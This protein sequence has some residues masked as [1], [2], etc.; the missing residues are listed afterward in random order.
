MAEVVHIQRKPND[1]KKD[2]DIK[3]RQLRQSSDGRDYCEE[4]Y[5]W[6][7]TNERQVIKSAKL[8]YNL[9]DDVSITKD[10]P[11]S[12]AVGH[13]TDIKQPSSITDDIAV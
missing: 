5:S 9:A 6:N 2:L 12:I 11:S 7:I 4:S 10:R 3:H 8:S 1:I 13:Q